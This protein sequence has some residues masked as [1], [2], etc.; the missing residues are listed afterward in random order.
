MFLV[1]LMACDSDDA[2]G[3]ARKRARAFLDDHPRGTAIVQVGVGAG[4]SGEPPALVGQVG[5][6]WSDTD[7]EA[8]LAPCGQAA[9]LRLDA[10]LVVEPGA[11]PWEVDGEGLHPCLAER[12]AAF[13]F[14]E[15]S[16]RGA[17]DLVRVR[18][19]PGEITE[20]VALVEGPGEDDEAPPH[21]LWSEAPPYWRVATAGAPHWERLLHREGR[22][23]LRPTHDTHVVEGPLED[24]DAWARQLTCP[25]ETLGLVRVVLAFTDGALDARKTVPESECVEERI[26]ESKRWMRDRPL[27][28][29]VLRDARHALVVLDVPVGAW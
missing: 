1:L 12:L 7:L 6:R 5:A 13:P 9:E 20:P 25:A 19:R 21:G 15:P 11:S 28:A 17:R 2:V 26:A 27:G 24:A 16:Q 29:T 22:L 3:V 14:E 10:E 23:L 18:W 4:A 8:W